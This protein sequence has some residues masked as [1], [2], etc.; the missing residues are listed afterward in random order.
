[1]DQLVNKDEFSYC[2]LTSLMMNIPRLTKS[3]I[4]MRTTIPAAIYYM[5]ALLAM[6]SRASEQRT[7]WEQA[8]CPLFGGCPYLGG[9]LRFD[10]IIL[11]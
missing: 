8:F 11:Q 4:V 1:M 9:S 7:I 5:A 10:C 3:M 6:Y 2:A